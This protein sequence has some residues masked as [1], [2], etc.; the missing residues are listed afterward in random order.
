MYLSPLQGMYSYLSSTQLLQFA[1]C[2]LESHRFAKAFNSN[3]EQR[4][5]LWKAGQSVI[6]IQMISMLSFI[7][8][9]TLILLMRLLKFILLH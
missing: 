3:H 2:L 6:F 7:S 1:D 4:N 9:I 8:I 5:V